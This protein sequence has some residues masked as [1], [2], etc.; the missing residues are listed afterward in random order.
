MN[1][2][3]QSLPLA[4]FPLQAKT[5]LSYLSVSLSPLP[6]CSK[7]ILRGNFDAPEWPAAKQ[8]KEAV[9]N[10]SH[11]Y[12]LGPDEQLITAP[13]QA[14]EAL[15]QHYADYVQIDVSDYYQQLLLADSHDQNSAAIRHILGQLFHLDFDTFAV[16]QCQQTQCGQTTVLIARQEDGYL[17]QYR[18]SYGDYLWEYFEVLMQ[19]K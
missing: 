9:A 18:A 15:Q 7:L 3:D 2:V 14:I 19:A 12:W 11:A 6:P 16:G 13:Y 4:H 5:P 8:F 1:A 17:I 10:Q